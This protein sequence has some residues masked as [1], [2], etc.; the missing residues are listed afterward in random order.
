VII[1][2]EFDF[3]LV[4]PRLVKKVF[5][6]HGNAKKDDMKRCLIEK[7]VSGEIVLNGDVETLS[8]H[9]IDAIAVAHTHITLTKVPQEK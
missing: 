3:K 6:D 7:I 1:P 8:E 9:E 2:N 5:A 4:E